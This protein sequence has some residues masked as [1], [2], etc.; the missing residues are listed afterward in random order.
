MWHVERMNETAMPD[1]TLQGKIHVYTTRKR[2]R[3]R[4]TWLEDVHDDL[5]EMKVKGWGGKMKRRIVSDCSGGQSSP[6][7]VAPRGRKVNSNGS[8]RLAFGCKADEIS[9]YKKLFMRSPKKWKTDRLNH[10]MVTQ[11]WQSFIRKVMAQRGL[12]CQ[13]R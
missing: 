6:W 9:L 1:W 13:W 12:F 5:N 8:W 7:A 4:L 3:P 2:G 11:V 10:S